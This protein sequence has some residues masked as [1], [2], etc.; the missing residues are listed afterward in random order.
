MTVYRIVPVGNEQQPIGSLRVRMRN[1]R[2]AEITR[3]LESKRKWNTRLD[4]GNL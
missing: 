2:R 3:A 1:D 4:A